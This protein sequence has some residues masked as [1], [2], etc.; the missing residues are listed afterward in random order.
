MP[1]SF[2][3]FTNGLEPKQEE[4]KKMEDNYRKFTKEAQE[5]EPKIGYVCWE[6]LTYMTHGTKENAERLYPLLQTCAATS[7]QSARMELLCGMDIDGDRP[8]EEEYC[9]KFIRLIRN[10]P[11]TMATILAYACNVLFDAIKTKDG[12]KTEPWWPM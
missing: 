11:T 7:I 5:F 6:I 9:D 8:F 10:N 4:A 1:V 3:I 12:W 2:F